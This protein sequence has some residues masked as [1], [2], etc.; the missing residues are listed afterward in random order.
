MPTLLTSVNN[1][2]GQ[3]VL[4]KKCPK[5]DGVIRDPFAID[6]DCLG[7]DFQATSLLHIFCFEKRST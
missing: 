3:L 2:P 1:I 6:D 4:L 5:N 7:K